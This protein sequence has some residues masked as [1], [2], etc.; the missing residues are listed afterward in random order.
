MAAIIFDFD[1]T[2]ADSLDYFVDFIAREANILSLTDEQRKS[3]QGLSLIGIARKLGHPWWKMPMLYY[4]GRHLMEP[5]ISDLKPFKGMPELIKKL[6]SEGHQLFII[7]SNSVRNMRIFLRRQ[8][9][10]KSFLEIYG[11]VVVFGKAP[12]IRELL[13][14][15]HISMKDAVYIGDELRDVE[16]AH[17]AGLRAVAV[18]WGFADTESL[19]ALKPYAMA[20]S[21]DELMKILE[22]I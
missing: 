21:P 12:V 14:A 10:R 6:H 1:G 22:Q 3:L 7:S 9:L 18:T 17:A 15:N 13:H 2:I 16:A 4:K 8:H 11:G 20:D 5:I 19:K